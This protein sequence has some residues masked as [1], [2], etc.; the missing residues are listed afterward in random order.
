MKAIKTGK[1]IRGGRLVARALLLTIAAGGLVVTGAIAPNLLVALKGLSQWKDVLRSEDD[2][3]QKK[4][5]LNGFSYLLSRGLI[6]KNYRGKQLY[7]SLSPMG[8]KKQKKYGIDF[9]SIKRQT[10]WDGKWR[11]LLFDVEE[12]RK[13]TRE[14]LRGKLKDLGFFQLQKSVWIHAFPCEKE[15]SSL[16]SFFEIQGEGFMCFEVTGLPEVFVRSVK[17]HFQLK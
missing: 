14:A 9:M 3:E 7:I 8:R 15:L 16:Q 11:M 5:V 13:V 17:E 6:R 2:R 10:R 4:K 1:G 12:K